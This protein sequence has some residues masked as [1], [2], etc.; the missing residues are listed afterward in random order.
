MI[1]DSISTYLLL[2]IGILSLIIAIAAKKNSLKLVQNMGAYCLFV[3]ITS[4]LIAILIDYLFRFY[5][6]Y[7][8][9]SS[10][11]ISPH[12]L[13]E[14]WKSKLLSNSI[15]LF[16]K[17]FPILFFLSLIIYK[18]TK[19]IHSFKSVLSFCLLLFGAFIFL[20][21]NYSSFTTGNRFA[22]YHFSY[23]CLPL[24]LCVWLFKIRGNRT[25]EIQ[26][27]EDILDV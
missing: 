26:G 24:I 14:N 6:T 13:F 18:N 7:E 3:W 19:T 23:Y 11:T 16:L 9:Y 17:G 20:S 10:G 22:I 27:Y 25:L 4:A 5:F 1:S 15:L 21:N 2:F 8:I 12:L